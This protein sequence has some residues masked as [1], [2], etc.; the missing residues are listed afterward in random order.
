MDNFDI[1]TY[2]LGKSTSKYS[3]LGMG[4]LGEYAFDSN[5]YITIDVTSL[6]GVNDSMQ[7]LGAR[8]KLVSTAGNRSKVLQS[9]KGEIL[10]YKVENDMFPLSVN[11]EARLRSV[12]G[13]IQLKSE[14]NEIINRESGEFIF[15]TEDYTFSFTKGSEYTRDEF[16]EVLAMEVNALKAL[17]VEYGTLSRRVTKVE[18]DYFNLENKL[19][20]LESSGSIVTDDNGNI[21]NP[22]GAFSGLA[23]RINEL[24]KKNLTRKES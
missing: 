12:D 20:Q 5:G 22:G 11:V 13:D 15:E 23:D 14:N 21:V 7:L 24:L 18:G 1:N 10:R 8:I 16:I 19:N 9:S 3:S 17:K 4:L 2:G 6:R